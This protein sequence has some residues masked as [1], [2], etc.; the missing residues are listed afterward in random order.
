M[1]HF[2][3]T[4]LKIRLI[5]R[6]VFSKEQ[7]FPSHITH[8]WKGLLNQ[9]S[10]YLSFK[11]IKLSPPLKGLLPLLH[12]CHIFAQEPHFIPPACMRP[13]NRLQLHKKGGGRRCLL[14]K[15]WTLWRGINPHAGDHSQILLSENSASTPE[16]MQTFFVV[17]L[18]V[19]I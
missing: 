3:T 6:S 10:K 11:K 18:W 15:C 1:L 12:Q 19:C 2:L 4:A 8:T 17:C 9:S 7:C 16:L 13:T 5:P 14:C